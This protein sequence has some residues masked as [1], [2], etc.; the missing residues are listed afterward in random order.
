[1]PRP[2]YWYSHAVPS[3]PRGSRSCSGLRRARERVGHLHVGH[4]HFVEAVL[5]KV[6][7]RRSQ[8]AFGFFRQQRQRVD[9][10]ARSDDVHARLLTL[11]VHQSQLQHRSHVKRRHEA[12]KCHLKFF[13]GVSAQLHSRIQ[14]IGGLPV[15]LGL[16]LLL[17]RRWHGGDFRPR[18]YVCLGRK[19]CRGVYRG[20]SFASRSGRR[21][22]PRRLL[23]FGHILTQLPVLRE[24]ATVGHCE[25]RFLSLLSHSECP[26]L[27]LS[28]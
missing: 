2:S 22:S 26:C 19:R 27:S 25:P 21:G 6:L 4:A 28:F 16:R 1:M 3:P 8:V 20:C 18:G 15:S 11:L 24:Q 7:F 14:H 12:L 5:K 23:L 9:G 17:G 13:G 10:L